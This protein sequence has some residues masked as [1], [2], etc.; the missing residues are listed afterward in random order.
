M[1][2]KTVKIDRT[3]INLKIS[4]MTDVDSEEYKILVGIIRKTLEEEKRSNTPIMS[5]SVKE[6]E[7]ER[8]FSRSI[9]MQKKIL[10]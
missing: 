7:A 3:I 4:S 10:V 1:R 6:D 9:H 8:L 5:V 2:S